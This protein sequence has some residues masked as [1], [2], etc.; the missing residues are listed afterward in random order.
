MNNACNNET[1]LY[2]E[3]VIRPANGW[4]VLIASVLVFIAAIVGTSFCGVEMERGSMPATVGFIACTIYVCV[5]WIFW[6][7]LKVIRPNEALV[8][9]LFGKYVGTVK[10]E[11]FFFVNPFCISVNPAADTAVQARTAPTRQAGESLSLNI[12]P[13]HGQKGVPEGVHPR[14]REAENQR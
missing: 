5:G 12:A 13:P 8:L 4:R 6:L 11:G 2:D 9:T 10:T 7:G 14:Q 1:M 3:K